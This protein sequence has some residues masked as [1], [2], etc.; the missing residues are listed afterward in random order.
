MPET[1]DA[2][3][4]RLLAATPPTAPSLV[5]GTACVMGGSIAGSLAARVLSDFA[6]RVVVIE[7]DDLEGRQLRR[8]GAPHAEQFHILLPAGASWMERW[9]TDFGTMLREAGAVVAGT[10]TTLTALDGRRQALSP[11]EYRILCASRP[12]IESCV[13]ASVLALPNVTLVRGRATGLQFRGSAVHAVE[14]SDGRTDDS[15]RADFVVDATGRSSRLPD[16]LRRGGFQQP[17]LDRLAVPLNYAT[18]K[19][20][21]LTPVDDLESLCALATYGPGRAVG[22]VSIAA[23]SVIENDQWMVALIGY[24][25]DRPGRTIDGL[26]AACAELPPVFG[27]AV[28]GRPTR[29]IVSHH[30]AETR[31]RHFTGLDRFPSGLVAVGDAVASFN[32]IYGQGMSSAAL[33]ASCLLAFLGDGGPADAPARHFFDMQEAVVDAAWS[34]SAGGDAARLDAYRG[35]DVAPEVHRQRWARQQV[36]QASLSDPE[37]AGVFKDVSYMLRHPA[38]LTDPALIERAASITSASRR[39]SGLV[40]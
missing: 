2:L 20:E 37:I 27:E 31:R 3:F 32:P 18:G 17:R 34:V 26:R 23:A 12:V 28:R 22:D 25:P 35:I 33:H 13:R 24:A 8:P 1:A 19:F 15:L 7:R 16:W 29:G 9:L 10:A 30:Q 36:M 5:I 38:A 21:R 39:A 11:R 14:Y 4:G 40:R 6:E